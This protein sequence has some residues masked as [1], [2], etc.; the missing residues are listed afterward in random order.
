MCQYPCLHTAC[1]TPAET[2]DETPGTSWNTDS[3]TSLGLPPSM[4]SLLL[5]TSLK[6]FF[7]VEVAAFISSRIL[8]AAWAIFT[9]KVAEKSWAL[10]RKSKISWASAA[11]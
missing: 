9:L 6:R 8:A 4:G 11:S 5:E 7:D 3:L 10:M 2:D 1:L